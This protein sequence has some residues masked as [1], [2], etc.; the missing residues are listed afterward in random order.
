MQLR[1]KLNSS[2]VLNRL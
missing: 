1:P 2:S